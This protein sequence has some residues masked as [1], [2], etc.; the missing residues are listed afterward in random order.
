MPFRPLR[1][2]AAASGG[3]FINHAQLHVVN[4]ALHCNVF[5]CCRRH[6]IIKLPRLAFADACHAGRFARCVLLRLLWVGLH[7]SN[8]AQLLV[9]NKDGG[10]T[11]FVDMGVYT[12][13]RWV[14]GSLGRLG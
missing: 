12:R 11:A 4:T 13:N 1:A 5:S 10:L 9:A 6:L 3:T 2:A 7:S 14:G 8:H